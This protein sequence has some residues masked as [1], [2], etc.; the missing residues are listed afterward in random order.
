M[1]HDSAEL[2]KIIVKNSNNKQNESP[3]FAC[4]NNGLFILSYLS[5]LEIL[6]K[7]L[8]FNGPFYCAV[9]NIL[10]K[11]WIAVHWINHSRL[12]KIL[13]VLIQ[14]IVRDLSAR[15]RCQPFLLD[16]A[17]FHGNEHRTVK[18]PNLCELLI[19]L[20]KEKLK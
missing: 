17:L 13:L 4:S 6:S 12:D 20:I 19:H 1:K 15:G 10:F 9:T 3:L 16:C 14:W 18:W 2:R 11:D 7:S 8:R 5:F